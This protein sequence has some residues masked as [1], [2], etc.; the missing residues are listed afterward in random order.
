MVV[1]VCVICPGKSASVVFGE[2]ECSRGGDA[3]KGSDRYGRP[4]GTWRHHRVMPYLM[5]Y[6][7]RGSGLR[8]FQSGGSAGIAFDSQSTP[9]VQREA[10]RTQDRPQVHALADGLSLGF[11]GKP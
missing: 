7:G 2:V 5:K 3:C 1:V 9:R 6:S 4:A 8:Y 11:H 10:D